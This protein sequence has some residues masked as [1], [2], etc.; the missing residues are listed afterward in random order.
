MTLSAYKALN[1][2]ESLVRGLRASVAESPQNKESK[3]V[4]KTEYK[5]RQGDGSMIRIK[6]L[7]KP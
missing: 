2:R 1:T 6:T 7:I 5:E 3:E 4:Q